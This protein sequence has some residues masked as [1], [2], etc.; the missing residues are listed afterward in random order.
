MATRAL[1]VDDLPTNIDLA[2]TV[3]EADGFVV[4]GA[5]DGAEAMNK[6]FRFVPDVILMD[7]RMP[8]LDGLEL[9]TILK[10]T[11]ATSNIVVIAFTAYY[12][13]MDAGLL[14][15]MGWEGLLAKPIQVA[16]FAAQVRSE[17]ETASRQRP[18]TGVRESTLRI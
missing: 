7:I 15:R 17:M 18:T 3:L 12:T 13:P 16:T 8:G 9:K 2:R 1:V 5:C 14:R 10:S 6:V 11:R 4:E